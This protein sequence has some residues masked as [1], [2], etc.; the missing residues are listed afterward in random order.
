MV[1]KKK[2]EPRKLKLTKL[3]TKENFSYANNNKVNKKGEEKGN[4][5]KD[6]E[7]QK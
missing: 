3:V 6:D 4:E 1:G 2:K 5:Q 7:G